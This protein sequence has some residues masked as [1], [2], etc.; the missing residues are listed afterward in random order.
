MNI[1]CAMISVMMADAVALDNGAM[2]I[3]VEPSVFS[4]RFVGFPGGS[5][6]LDPL[7]VSPEDSAGTAWLDPG[8]LVT[9][10][11]PLD[12]HDGPLR[13]GPG[14]VLE[15]RKDYVALLGPVSKATGLRMKKEFKIDEKEAKA[16]YTV[17]VSVVGPKAVSCSVRNTA[18]LATG[19]TL[20]VE[21]TDGT[22][23]VLAGA[24]SILPAVVNSNQFW[25]VPIPPTARMKNVV[26]GAFIP[27]VVHLTNQG[28]W[29][30]RIVNPPSEAKSVPSESSFVCLLDSDTRSFGGALQGATAPLEPCC[31]M[32][33]E[34]E[35]T[36]EKRGSERAFRR[37]ASG[38]NAAA[39]K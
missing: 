8:G 31:A 10:L 13:R 7:Y 24:D 6:F 17:S 3:E 11:V 30:R 14:E 33:F 22:I 18:R 16:L 9:D 19:S 5:N 23:R 15:H 35:W 28:S 12:E 29:T 32:V 36:L 20:R 1:L 4:V 2:R 38:P 34:E 25:I 26:L 39:T 27:K 37:P 21:K